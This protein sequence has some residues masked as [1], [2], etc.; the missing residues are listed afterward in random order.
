MAHSINKALA[1][2][3]AQAKVWFILVYGSD[4][5]YVV[6]VCDVFCLCLVFW[7]GSARSA[8]IE[9]W[10]DRDNEDVCSCFVSFFDGN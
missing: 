6:L 3:I 5:I 8:E 9:P 2:N 10:A 7:V 1:W 4:G